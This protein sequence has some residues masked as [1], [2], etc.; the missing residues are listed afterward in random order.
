[1]LGFNIE[2]GSKV[3]ILKGE[4]KMENQL[5]AD[6]ITL[7]GLRILLKDIKKIAGPKEAVQVSLLLWHYD[8]DVGS[9]RI[10]EKIG[11]YYSGGGPTREFFFLQDAHKYLETLKKEKTND[12]E[13]ITTSTR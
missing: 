11:V 9:G 7:A 12:S 4:K 1:M 2:K 3:T 8:S 6:N 10:V 13:S 5:L